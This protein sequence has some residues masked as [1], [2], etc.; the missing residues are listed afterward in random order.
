MNATLTCPPG[1]YM[2]RPRALGPK[3]E[4]VRSPLAH[5]IFHDMSLHVPKNCSL[6]EREAGWSDLTGIRPA[7][8]WAVIRDMANLTLICLMTARM[9]SR[10]G[11]TAQQQTRR[12]APHPT[13]P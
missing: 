12:Y 7:I 2:M 3:G 13:H 5:L 11:A 10:A 1:S 9:Q 6:T 4:S 8:S